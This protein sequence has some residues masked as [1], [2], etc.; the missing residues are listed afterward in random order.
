[1][2]P[3]K[4]KIFPSNIILNI[5]FIFLDYHQDYPSPPSG[6]VLSS[7]VTDDPMEVFEQM[8]KERDDRKRRLGNHHRRN[9]NR[10]TSRSPSRSSSFNRS[11]PTYLSRDDDRHR[12][13]GDKS[14][15]QKHEKLTREYDDKDRDYY[16]QYS[17]DRKRARRSVSPFERKSRSESY[18]SSREANKKNNK[19]REDKKKKIGSDVNKE[20]RMETWKEAKENKDLNN[21]HLKLTSTSTKKHVLSLKLTI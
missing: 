18:D 5:I 4:L 14:R 1:M 13:I 11:S 16:D 8:L 21:V 19:D 9:R 15:S 3:N 7:K 17:G 10:S 20:K 6:S 12:G 2:L